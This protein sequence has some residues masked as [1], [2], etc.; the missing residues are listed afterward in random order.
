MP[1]IED[2]GYAVIRE[3][4]TPQD[5]ERHAASLGERIAEEL[6]AL[7]DGAHAYVARPAAVPLHTDHPDV[8]RIGWFCHEQD[9]AD[10]ASWLLDTRPVLEGL[11][12]VVLEELRRTKLY[13]QPV[14]E[15]APMEV[16]AVL[17]GVPSHPSVYFPPWRVEPE[18]ISWNRAALR[19]LVDRLAEAQRT[20]C[21][22]VRLA[23]G[24]A[25]FV[26][27]ARV[28]H[29]RGP[30]HPGSQRRLKRL[31]LRAQ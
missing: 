9:Q 13:C 14:H 19:L 17:S 29:G 12:A 18:P 20:S 10:G 1:T 11:P 21:I 2:D 8:D 5:F 15:G 23:P 27:N 3:I 7:R 16:R 26:D 30:L 25:L 28:L 6:I 22:H 4:G 24:D 31:W